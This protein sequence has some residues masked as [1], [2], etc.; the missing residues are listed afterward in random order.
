MWNVGALEIDTDSQYRWLTVD[1]VADIVSPLSPNRPNQFYGISA[2]STVNVLC[3]VLHWSIAQ[4]T[5]AL[6]SISMK[7]YLMCTSADCWIHCCCP[8]SVANKCSRTGLE[9]FHS[10]LAQQ[11]VEIPTKKHEKHFLIEKEIIRMA[12]KGGI[13]MHLSNLGQSLRYQF[14][15]HFIGGQRFPINGTICCILSV[16]AVRQQC[17]IRHNIIVV[18]WSLIRK[19][20]SCNW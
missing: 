16:H 20:I 4:L 9:W 18:K 2:Q 1:A 7:R 8:N 14:S 19:I 3:C 6:L 17:V 10:F 11:S 12:K 5:D 15:E 13:N